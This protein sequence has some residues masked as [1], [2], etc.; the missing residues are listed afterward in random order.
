MSVGLAGAGSSGFDV[1]ADGSLG[2]GDRAIFSVTPD[3]GRRG[4]AGLFLPFF[5]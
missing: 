3:E 1:P 2:T 5:F 4:A